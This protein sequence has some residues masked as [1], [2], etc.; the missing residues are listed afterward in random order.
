MPEFLKL[1]KLEQVH[2][3]EIKTQ[4]DLIRKAEKGKDATK[5]TEVKKGVCRICGCTETTP[6][7]DKEGEACMWQDNS[8]TLCSNPKCIAESKKQAKKDKAGKK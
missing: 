2:K 4:L 1:F 6:C 5:L 7:I 3:D 8:E